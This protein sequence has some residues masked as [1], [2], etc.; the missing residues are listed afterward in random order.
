[1]IFF[2]TGPPNGEAV[3]SNH[4]MRLKTA[5][6]VLAHEKNHGRGL[7][8]ELC[9]VLEL[10]MRG[11]KEE[12]VSEERLKGAGRGKVIKLIN[13]RKRGNVEGQLA[14]DGKQK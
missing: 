5:F 6:L 12:S 1:M 14:K 8:S 9:L 2:R 10:V 11:G 3:G 13:A 4:T 7:K